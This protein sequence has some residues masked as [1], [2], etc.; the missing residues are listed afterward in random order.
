M[1]KSIDDL[2]A[3]PH[4]EP[5]PRGTDWYRFSQDITDLLGTGRATWAFDT[6]TDIQKTVELTQRVTD[7]QRR[8]FN[9]I[10]ERCAER[11]RRGVSRR[12]EGWRRS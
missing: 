5:D 1:P 11:P 10:E 4:E 12:Y 9:N 3:K 6:L 7:G 2:D 8:A